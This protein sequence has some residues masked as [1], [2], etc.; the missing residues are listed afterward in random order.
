MARTP[1]GFDIVRHRSSHR[2]LGVEPHQFLHI[3]RINPTVCP[4]A[5]K[6]SI[7]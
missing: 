2:A 3:F 7:A 4:L 5:A 1:G 6:A